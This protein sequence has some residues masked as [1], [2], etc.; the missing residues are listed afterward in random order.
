MYAGREYPA[1][2]YSGQDLNGHLPVFCY[3]D[4]SAE[5]FESHLRYLADNCYATLNCDELVQR[6]SAKRPATARSDTREVTLTFDDG[7]AGFYSRVYPLLQK[8]RMKAVAYIVP[9]WIGHPGFLTWEQCRDM[10]ASGWVD[11]QSHSYAHARLVT[12]LTLTRIW[13]RSK[14]SPIPWGIPGFDPSFQDGRISCLP[15]LK[16][17]SLFSGQPCLRIPEGFWQECAHIEPQAPNGHLERRYKILLQEYGHLVSRIDRTRLREWM[18]EDLRHSRE[19]I[20]CAIPGHSVRHFAFPWHDNSNLAWE[21]AEAAGYVSAAIGLEGTDQS[22]G[23]CGDLS[24]I[25]RVNADFL[26][27]LP[28]RHRSSFLRVLAMKAQRRARGHHVYG[29]AN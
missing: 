9:A 15:V 17:A 16:G 12:S 25:M 7:L 3:H 11:V 23:C 14:D 8:Y 4:I 24:R 27:C 20:E 18:G 5:D 29:I 10:Q 6:L 21:A 22:R 2:L 28:G 19:D 1:F 13:R 26:P